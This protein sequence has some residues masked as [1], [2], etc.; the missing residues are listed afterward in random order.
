MTLRGR[1]ERPSDIRPEV[2]DVLD[3]D[4]EAHEALVRQARALSDRE[5]DYLAYSAAYYVE[6]A[7]RHR[8]ALEAP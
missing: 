5:K 4:A 1:L 2:V 8:Q 7:R 6:L 3:A